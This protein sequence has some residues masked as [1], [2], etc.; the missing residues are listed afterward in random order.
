[1]SRDYWTENMCENSRN[2]PPHVIVDLGYVKHPASRKRCDFIV[3]MGV[4]KQN[5]QVVAFGRLVIRIPPTKA[6]HVFSMCRGIRKR[7]TYSW[8]THSWIPR[9]TR[10]LKYAS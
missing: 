10:N 7:K 3:A 4:G 1:M 9:G 6:K 5:I 8:T 2:E